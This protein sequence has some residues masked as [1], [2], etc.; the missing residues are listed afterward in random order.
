M[1]TSF[2]FTATAVLMSC[3]L[4]G[5]AQKADR[6]YKTDGSS[7]EAYV[8]SFDAREMTYKV[9]STQQ[10]VRIPIADLWKVE[11]GTGG[12]RL[13][14]N[15]LKNQPATQPPLSAPKPPEAT[16]A[17][18]PLTIPPVPSPAARVSVSENQRPILAITFGADVSYL[19]PN[20]DWTELP[21]GVGFKFGYG[22]S[23]RVD[24]YL[25]RRVALTFSGGLTQWSVERKFVTN[26]DQLI[27][28]VNATLRQ[29]PVQGGVKFF[30]LKHVYVLP[31]AGV[32]FLHY[33]FQNTLSDAPTGLIRGTK[34]TYGIGIGLMVPSERWL[35]EVMPHVQRIESSQ[36]GT[37]T[38]LAPM[39]YAGVRVGVGYLAR[40]KRSE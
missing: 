38:D 16:Q 25:H 22:G 2:L 40:K 21:A 8:Q 15:P 10:V 29:Y 33:S 32:Q 5:W 24:L 9:P 35:I 11:Y 36:L 26:T 14:S 18:V 31:Q 19:L 20:P 34:R 27:Y 4:N 17:P 7:L 13:F 23:A 3:C 12:Q 30:L 1:K 37:F 39:Q 28:Q 6:I